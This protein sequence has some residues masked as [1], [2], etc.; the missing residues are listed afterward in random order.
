MSINRLRPVGARA[1]LGSSRV[2]AFQD[3]YS[4]ARHEASN[5]QANGTVVWRQS[6]AETSRSPLIGN[7][8][9]ERYSCSA[10]RMHQ[11]GPALTWGPTREVKLQ[12]IA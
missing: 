12:R 2:R 10:N 9:P 7:V 6:G 11:F 5:A 3:R 1:R 4:W 8:A